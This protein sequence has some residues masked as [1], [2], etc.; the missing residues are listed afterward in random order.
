MVNNHR[1][2]FIWIGIIVVV[3]LII[4]CVV[5]K[6]FDSDDKEKSKSIGAQEAFS[7]EK[8][9]ILSWD[10]MFEF[11]NGEGFESMTKESREKVIID[12]LDAMKNVYGFDS[13]SINFNANP[14]IVS[15]SYPDGHISAV[16]LTERNPEEN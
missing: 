3:V 15:L 14:L 1:I 11:V 16:Q 8:I 9:S 10:D 2:L 7:D 4:I 13:Y 5:I 12:A 6:P